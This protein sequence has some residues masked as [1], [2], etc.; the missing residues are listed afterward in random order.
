MNITMSYYLDRIKNGNLNNWRVRNMVKM[1]NL[2]I[3]DYRLTAM[4]ERG[5]TREYCNREAN[6]LEKRL[7][8][9]MKR[10]QKRLQ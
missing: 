6:L 8:E 4:M 10:G 2:E 1:V 5:F 3:S 9:A 7:E